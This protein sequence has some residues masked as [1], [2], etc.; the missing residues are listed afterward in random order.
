MIKITDIDSQ[1][2]R[3]E[4]PFD[5]EINARLKSD[6]SA[7]WLKS[8]KAWKIE[9]KHKPNVIQACQ[10]FAKNGKTEREGSEGENEDLD[11]LTVYQLSVLIVLN[12]LPFIIIVAGIIA[13]YIGFIKQSEEIVITAMVILSVYS[14]LTDSGGFE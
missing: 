11:N 4:I 7:A 12:L 5:R 10:K 2:F 14:L 6:F 1:F 3:L 9:M 13:L 8:E